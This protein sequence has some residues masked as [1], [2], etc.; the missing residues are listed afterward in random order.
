MTPI[1]EITEAIV[2]THNDLDAVGSVIALKSAGIKTIAVEYNTYQTIDN[3]LLRATQQNI[4][5]IVVTDI[6]PSQDTCSKLDK[7]SVPLFL[8]DHHKTR[9]FVEKYSWAEFSQSQC[10][11]EMVYAAL[12]ER[13]QKNN[14]QEYVN[15]LTDL[16]DAIAAWDM[17]KKDS[18]H[19]T[20]GENLNALVGFIGTVEF[21]NLFTKNPEA[22]STKTLKRIIEYINEKKLRYITQVINTQFTHIKVE[23]DGY[24][25]KF[26]VLIATDYISELGDAIL[27]KE[28]FS[29]IDY[30]CIVNPNWG[31]CS[32]RSRSQEETDVERIAKAF[33]GG[34]HKSAAGFPTQLADRNKQAI[35]SQLNKLNY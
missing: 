16:M 12:K 28:D 7:S 32:L 23:V 33:G 34:G 20:R 8:F 6:C 11:A 15:K 14:T 22:D 35:I 30:V 4:T 17:W 19:R 5:P 3:A 26:V 1:T 10:G 13:I 18:P 2:E 24:N 21:A 31:T 27:E 25:H 29:D 9:K